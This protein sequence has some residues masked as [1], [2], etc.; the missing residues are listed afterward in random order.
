[1]GNPAK[2]STNSD[3]PS[4]LDQSVSGKTGGQIVDDNQIFLPLASTER[5][6]AKVRLVGVLS[7]IALLTFDALLPLG[8]SSFAQDAISNQALED[9]VEPEIGRD[10]WRER[11]AEAK[12]RARQFALEQRE[13]LTF[14]ATPMVDEES[15]ASER[16][17]NDDSL[18]RGD[19]VSTNKGLF[20]FRGRSDQEHRESDF[21]PLPPR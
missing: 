12:R 7:G 3:L 20:V 4:R 14:E 11:V 5:R 21:I 1:M 13:R 2:L 16:V 9:G 15:M 6:L 8:A 18:R 19:I 17:L 10:Q